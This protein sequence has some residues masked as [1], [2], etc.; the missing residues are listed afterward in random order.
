[1][2]GKVTSRHDGRCLAPVA[3]DA[4]PLLLKPASMVEEAGFEP[5]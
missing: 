5:A 4:D 2:S 3:G 1:M